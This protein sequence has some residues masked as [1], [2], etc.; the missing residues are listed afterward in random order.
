MA[1]VTT[2]DLAADNGASLVG[3]IQ[4]DANA[5]ART[6]EDK[7]RDTVHVKDFGAV[8]DGTTD[9]TDAI[10]DAVAFV[11]DNANFALH[12]DDATYLVGSSVT[13]GNSIFTLDGTDGFVMRGRPNFRITGT[14]AKQVTLF[15][16]QMSN[17]DIEYIEATGDEWTAATLAI[18]LANGIITCRAYSPT[19]ALLTDHKFGTIRVTNGLHALLYDAN[20]KSYGLF[21][22]VTVDLI[23]VTECAYAFN[24]AHAPDNH[25]IGLIVA[26]NV[27]RAYFVY[28]VDNGRANVFVKPSYTGIFAGGTCANIGVITESSSG[29]H[30]KRVRSTRNIEAN[31]H[32]ISDRPSLQLSTTSMA[33][34]DTAQGLYNI[35][36]NVMSETGNALGVA[37]ADIATGTVDTSTP[38]ASPKV[39]ITIRA[40]LATA[41]GCLN[42]SSYGIWSGARGLTLECSNFLDNSSAVRQAYLTSGWQIRDLEYGFEIPHALGVGAIGS[43]GFLKVAVNEDPHLSLGDDATNSTR[44]R[45]GSTHTWFIGG[46]LN[47]YMSTSQFYPWTDNTMTLGTSAKRF[48]QTYSAEVRP[49]VGSVIWTSGSGTPEGAVIAPI[50]SLFTRSDGGT[51]TTLYVKESGTGNTGWVP[52]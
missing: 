14:N 23:D 29:A 43:T 52:K 32:N 26:D 9:D 47:A 46:A 28:G 36:A 21:D 39:N 44:Y 38:Y 8:G 15:D 12:F 31:I 19:G 7:L 27:F 49:G 45:A 11:L 17:L 4:P 25:K 22:G 20:D 34:T 37:N 10:A 51:G 13:T 42:P 30:S 1:Y 48:S 2:T 50:G 24:G 18:A 3:F 40:H 41:A 5:V 6:V 33:P 35:R 16:I